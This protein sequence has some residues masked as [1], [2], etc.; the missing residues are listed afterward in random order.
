MFIL[1]FQDSVKKNRC[2]SELETT[3][4]RDFPR[5]NFGFIIVVKDEVSYS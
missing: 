3:R 1:P 2:K 5:L 4:G